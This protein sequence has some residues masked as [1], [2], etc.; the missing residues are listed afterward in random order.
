MDIEKTI[1]SPPYLSLSLS[2]FLSSSPSLSLSPQLIAK[3]RREEEV[4]ASQ[5]R[6]EPL[7][8]IHCTIFHYHHLSLSPPV[9]QGG[10]QVA[11]RGRDSPSRDWDKE[12]VQL[13]VKAVSL[14]P[15]GTSRRWA[16]VAAHP[17]PGLPLSLLS[18]SPPLSLPPSSS[19][20]PSLP[21]PLPLPPSPGGK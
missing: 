2:P 17:T 20:P 13:L 5:A 10:A 21:H 7:S 15:A 3:R 16:L 8:L 4:V 12:Q 19:P 1:A 14:Y 9:A 11:G 6:R 18:S